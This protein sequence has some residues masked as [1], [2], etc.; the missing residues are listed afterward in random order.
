MTHMPMKR[1]KSFN[2]ARRRI[3]AAL[4]IHPSRAVSIHPLRAIMRN[5]ERDPRVVFGLLCSAGIARMR[6][7][8]GEPRLSSRKTEI[9]SAGNAVTRKPASNQPQ[10]SHR[11]TEL[12]NGTVV[13]T[14]CYRLLGRAP[15]RLNLEHHRCIFPKDTAAT[16]ECG[17]GHQNGEWCSKADA[18]MDSFHRARFFSNG[19]RKACSR[20][21]ASIETASFL[22]AKDEIAIH[23]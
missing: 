14:R 8:V 2:R 10:R 21:R 11:R 22:I 4:D 17:D 13:V 7:Q 1:E 3:I 5:R 15:T 9:R 6:L 20:V 19:A 23:L 16:G 12:P 18:P